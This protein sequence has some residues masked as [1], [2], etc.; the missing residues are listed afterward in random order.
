[1]PEAT[2]TGPTPSAEAPEGLRPWQRQPGESE[3][4]YRAFAC[5]LNLL[6]RRTVE[7][8]GRALYPGAGTRKRGR[9]GRL[10]AWFRRWSWWDRATAWDDH[11]WPEV[12]R[13]WREAR[14]EWSRRRAD[15]LYARQMARDA[16]YP[17]G[18]GW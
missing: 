1:M 10:Q 8:V 16:R 3:A 13:Q 6:G 9:T 15:A 7:A 18:G 4:A 12:E 5:Y 14:V 2:A 11:C 17:G